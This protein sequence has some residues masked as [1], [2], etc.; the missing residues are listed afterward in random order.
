MAG[1][2]D[3]R[4][5]ARGSEPPSGRPRWLPTAVLALA[6][7]VVGLV[8]GR[9]TA[10]DNSPPATPDRDR[11]TATGPG[12]TGERAGVPVGYARTEEGAATALLNYG[13]VLS[14]L[15]LKPPAERQAA[16]DA[17][18]TSAFVERTARQLERARTAAERGP[19]GAALRGQGTAVYRGGPLG[20]RVTRFAENEAEID[21]WA[22]GLVAATTGLDPQMTFQTSTNTLV[23][24]DGDWKLAAS[25]SRRGPAPAVDAQQ[26]ISGRAFV[27]GVGRLKEL[28][29]AP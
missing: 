29:Y 8:I 17:F 15:L 27:G 10:P 1:D 6:V 25:E 18:G 5:V 28:R 14:R 23:W 13:V 22:F 21:T 16:L 26:Q 19:L 24:Q 9:A 7:L 3:V 20:Y 4:V 11:P 2:D 12:P